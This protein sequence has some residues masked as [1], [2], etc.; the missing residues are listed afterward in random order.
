MITLEGVCDM[1]GYRGL[2]STWVRAEPKYIG[3]VEVVRPCGDLV[4]NVYASPF[5]TAG[6]TGLVLRIKLHEVSLVLLG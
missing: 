6:S 5:E 2:S 1:R 3:P 4:D